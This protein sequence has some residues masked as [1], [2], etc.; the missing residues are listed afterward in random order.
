MIWVILLFAFILRLITLGQSLWLDEAINVVAAKN[1]DFFSFVSKYPIGDYHPPGYFTILWIWAH[2]FGFGEMVVRMPSVLFGLGTVSITYLLGKEL[3]DK[4]VAQL[5]ALFLA[6]APLH[7]YYSQEARMYS[8]SAFAATLSFYFLVK[9]VKGGVWVKWGYLAS[10]V[11]ILYSDYVT[12]LVLPAQMFFLIF[13]K[14]KFVRGVRGVW[15]VWGVS[16]LFLLPWLSVLPLQIIEGMKGSAD[17]P[18]WK[19]VAGGANIKDLILVWVKMLIGRISFENKFIYGG[20]IGFL[21]ILWI[22]GGIGGVWGI[23]G[24]GGVGGVRG[25]REKLKYQYQILL[26]WVIVPLSLAWGISFFIPILSYFRIL[27]ILPAFYLFLA[28]SLVK[29]PKIFF[30]SITFILILSSLIFLSIYYTNPKFQRED[31]RGAVNFL[32]TVSGKESV[33]LFENNIIPSPFVYYKKD[34]NNSSAGLKK[35][36]ARSIGDVGD[37]GIILNKNKEIYL[38]EYLVEITD[39]KR[40]LEEK[41]RQLGFSQKNIYNFEGLGFIR[42]Y[43]KN[44]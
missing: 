42:H 16:L 43:Q 18:E 12:Y 8:L 22:L 20:V 26:I 29:L 15:E 38:F 41:I 28:A 25:I 32:N 2:I 10:V 19:K 34:L 5:S 44:D 37:M 21:S 24:V 4:K 17:L 40:L 39:P 11:L 36:Q 7:V 3:F 31:W 30:R 27:Y 35:I 13:N 1:L 33:V 9:W 6:V 14:D 23:G